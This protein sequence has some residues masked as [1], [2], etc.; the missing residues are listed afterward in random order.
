MPNVTIMVENRPV[1]QEDYFNNNVHHE[2][3]CGKTKRRECLKIL[4]QPKPG[5]DLSSCGGCSNGRSSEETIK[6]C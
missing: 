6:K 5:E 1:F 4:K 3:K 2:L